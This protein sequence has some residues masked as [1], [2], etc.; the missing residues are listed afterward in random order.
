M[1]IDLTTKISHEKIN[2]WLDTQENRHI[3]TGHVGTHLD[4]YQKSNIPLEYFERI[5]VLLDVSKIGNGRDIAISDIEHIEIPENSFVLFRTEQIEKYEYG[6]KEYFY[7]HP[8]LSHD[9]IDYLIDKKISFIGIDCSGIRRG[10]EHTPADIRCEKNGI[11]IIENLCNL[12]S[13]SSTPFTL[14]T[15]WL[16][17]EVA[18]GLQCRVLVKQ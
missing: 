4:T 1:I 10:D 14:Y 6:T 15:M 17:D 7:N 13:L 12:Q 16:D 18:T 3:A 5:G 2:A 8:Q 11:Y 9:L